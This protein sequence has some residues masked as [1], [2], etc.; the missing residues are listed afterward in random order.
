MFKRKVRFQLLEAKRENP[1]N[2]NSPPAMINVSD[3]P[4]NPKMVQDLEILCKNYPLK[5]PIM[6]FN[7]GEIGVPVGVPLI[8]Y[9]D[10][11]FTV[12]NFTQ[13]NDKLINIFVMYAGD[14]KISPICK[15]E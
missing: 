8:V 2:P 13:V 1:E 15:K 7:Q 10:K 14:P 11:L 5:M 4:N 3:D 9:D 6:I 12:Y